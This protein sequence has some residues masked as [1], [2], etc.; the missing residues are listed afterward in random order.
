MKYRGKESMLEYIDKPP[1]IFEQLFLIMKNENVSPYPFINQVNNVSH[2]ILQVSK[3]LG[4]YS[5]IS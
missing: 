5:N 4:K 1:D 3:G 2:D